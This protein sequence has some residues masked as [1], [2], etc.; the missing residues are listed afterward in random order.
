[1]KSPWK[2]LTQLGSRKRR[3]DPDESPVGG[4]ASEDTRATEASEEF[5]T[6]DETQASPV[7]SDIAPGAT[8]AGV[9]AADQVADEPAELSVDA[10][11]NDQRKIGSHDG[12]I[13][14]MSDSKPESDKRKRQAAVPQQ[15]R[16]PRKNHSSEVAQSSAA[17]ERARPEP[18]SLSFAI[19]DDKITELDQEIKHLRIELAQR[20]RLQ[21]DQL[22][23]MLKRFD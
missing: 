10:E 5:L 20:L 13:V 11:E 19:V 1:M 14:E 6:P 9:A 15:P 21:N 3:A 16:K 2:F 7:D 23:K 12:P 4:H 18:L 22:R 8:A 17:S